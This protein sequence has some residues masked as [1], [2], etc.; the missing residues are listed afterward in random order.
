MLGLLGKKIG[1]TQIFEDGK[2]IPVTVVEAGP[3]YI[4]Q[5]KTEEKEGYNA[6]Q[7][8]FGT[9]SEKNVNK[10]MMGIF[11]KANVGPLR[12]VKEF[13]V[14]NVD[15][16]ELGQVV[17]ADALSEI[18]YVDVVGTSK[19]KGYQ[20]VMKRHNFGGN[21]KTHGVSRAH[22][23]PG[24]IGQSSSPSKVL[25]GLKMAGQLGGV[26]VTVQ[27]LEVV[28]VD[29]ANNLLLIK[30]AVPGPKNGLLVIKPAVKKY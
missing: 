2:T 26:Q 13:K 5:K 7:V 30:G 12:F 24:S 25:K 29:V 23:S 3:N 9:K 8:G 17:K 28:K 4:L 27:N 11:K 21:R 19:G 6:I 1:M 22:R 20:G 16:F 15:E 18:K 10:P 14:D